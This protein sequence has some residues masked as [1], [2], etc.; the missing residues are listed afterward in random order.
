MKFGGLS[1]KGKHA[2]NQDAFTVSK[3]RGGYVI[4]VSDGLGFC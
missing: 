4:A 2:I 1:L 3:I